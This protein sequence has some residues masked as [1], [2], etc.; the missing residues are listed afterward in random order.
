[1]KATLDLNDKSL[2]KM[3]KEFNDIEREINRPEM[4]EDE[5]LSLEEN[6]LKQKVSIMSLLSSFSLIQ[7]STK[8]SY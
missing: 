7:D 5:R 1:M 4:Y 8:I 2:L 3:S 6:I